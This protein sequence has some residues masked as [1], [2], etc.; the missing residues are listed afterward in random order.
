MV[1]GIFL[2]LFLFPNFTFAFDLSLKTPLE[3]KLNDNWFSSNVVRSAAPGVKTEAQ[4]WIRYAKIKTKIIPIA[5]M[6]VFELQKKNLKGGVDPDY[7][8]IGTGFILGFNSWTRTRLAPNTYRYIG[9]NETKNRIMQVLWREAKDRFIY[10]VATVEGEVQ[11]PVSYEVEVLQ[12]KLVSQSQSV[13]EF[14]ALKYLKETFLPNYA[15]AE[16][17]PK[18]FYGSAEEV[19]ALQKILNDKEIASDL[20]TNLKSATAAFAKAPQVASAINSSGPNSVSVQAFEKIFSFSPQ[21]LIEQTGV[22]AVGATVS[23]IG[24]AATIALNRIDDLYRAVKEFLT[25]AQK[26]EQL[27]KDAKE[28]HKIYV[29]N[30]STTLASSDFRKGLVN[31]KLAL[32]K[33]GISQLEVA[34]IQ[35]KGVVYARYFER[36]KECKADAVQ[37][38][39]METLIKTLKELEVYEKTHFK[40]M[41]VCDSL[42]NLGEA[43]D[44]FLLEKY[45]SRISYF[46]AAKAIVKDMKKKAKQANNDAETAKDDFDDVV[47]EFNDGST[48]ELEGGLRAYTKRQSERMKPCLE[49]EK[50]IHNTK[51]EDASNKCRDYD[52]NYDPFGIKAKGDLEKLKKSK[53]KTDRNL[54]NMEVANMGDLANSQQRLKFYERTTDLMGKMALE[55]CIEPGSNCNVPR[56]HEAFN[57]IVKNLEEQ[58]MTQAE[59]RKACPQLAE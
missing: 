49:N 21:T 12:R 57:E 18:N 32:D 20:Y 42:E 16:G 1:R 56:D 30:S 48:G 2:A 44:S 34:T 25:D 9:Y 13:V 33:L 10:A 7:V 41:K 22:M 6:T 35:Q 52:R 59:L 51:P 58:R 8:N 15:Y 36:M 26:N 55:S 46:R 39:R 3:K 54:K 40:Y 31:L 24:A 29:Q 53:K 23:P 47:E 38:E 27:L 4:L 11:S 28:A 14:D 19:L 37:L 45:N 5:G 50:N 43:L 17:D